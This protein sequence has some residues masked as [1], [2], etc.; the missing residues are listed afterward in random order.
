MKSMRS[1]VNILLYRFFVSN[2][3]LREAQEDRKMMCNIRRVINDAERRMCLHEM[4]GGSCSED[5]G[6][7]V[8][9]EIMGMK[10]YA[11]RNT[12]K[13]TAHYAKCSGENTVVLLSEYRQNSH[14]GGDYVKCSLFK[15]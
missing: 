6:S 3:E 12:V 14:N 7:G 2:D 9:L 8:P 13:K 15:D 5:G 10:L 1:W 11:Y 4:K